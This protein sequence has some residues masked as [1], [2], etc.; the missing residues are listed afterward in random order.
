[1][2][3]RRTIAGLTLIEVLVGLVLLALLSGLAL[4]SF[5]NY[6]ER[7]RL[8]SAAETLASNLN[9]A[10][11]E[12]LAQQ[13]FMYVQL[14]GQGSARWCYTVSAAAKC[15][16][17]SAGCEAVQRVDSTA[18]PGV[19]LSSSSRSVFRFNWKNGSATG[20]NGTAAFEGK[21]GGQRLCVVLSNLGRV[22]IVT[23]RQNPVA[24]YPQD[25]ACS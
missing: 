22:R 15:D 10:R 17:L 18:L 9:L 21:Q 12:A 20:A 7:Q 11:S 5:N 1:M 3:D 13:Q 4:P 23:S 2:I 8:K 14:A 25:N 6:Q 19:A 16:C 24:G